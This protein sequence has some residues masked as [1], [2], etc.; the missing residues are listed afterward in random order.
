M[1]VGD[2]FLTLLI[3]T[4]VMIS[5]SLLNAAFTAPEN[6]KKFLDY[7]TPDHHERL[8]RVMYALVPLTV[9]VGLGRIEDGIIFGNPAIWF[10]I[11]HAGFFL[12]MLLC[13]KIVKIILPPE[14][15]EQTRSQE[16]QE[17][18]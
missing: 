13:R 18:K 5:G 7:I 6:C 2:A 10:A 4:Y 12:L 11:A 3:G 16:G 17:T 15:T 14:N 1:T 9:L 8:A